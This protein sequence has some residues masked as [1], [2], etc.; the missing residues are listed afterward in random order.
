M[1]TKGD[2]TSLDPICGRWVKHAAGE[3]IDYKKRTYFFCSVRCRERFEQQAERHRVQEL[4]RMG[5]L[6]GNERVRWGL[7]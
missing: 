3:T 5:A 4:A 2:E 7:A 1:Q 6:F